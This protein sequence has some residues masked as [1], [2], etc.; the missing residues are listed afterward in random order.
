MQENLRRAKL[1]SAARVVR[2]D[3]F[4]FLSAC[5]AKFDLILLDPPYA[6][7]ILENALTRISEIDILEEHGIIIAESPA[8]KALPGRFG[9]LAACKTRR[10]GQILL[11]EF[12]QESAR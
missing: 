4:A 7:Q 6:G 3:A 1:E 11:T 10:Y 5:R 8:D 2:S 12:R 9:P